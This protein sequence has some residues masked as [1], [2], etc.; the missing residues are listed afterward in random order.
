MPITFL[1]TADWQL[2]KPF[3]SVEDDDKRALIRQARIKAI[4]KIG[5]IAQE[6]NAS[7]ILVAGDLFDSPTTSKSTVSAACSNL[8]QLKIPVIVIPWSHQITSTVVYGVISS[9]LT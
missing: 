9:F 6:R 1:H 2:G 3:A 7:F 5:Q 8:G 4:Q